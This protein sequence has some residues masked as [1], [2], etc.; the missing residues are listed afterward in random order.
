MRSVEIG[1]SVAGLNLDD[2][3]FDGIWAELAA[4]D[5]LVLLHPPRVTAAAPRLGRYF[6]N[7]LIGNP[8]EN[9]LA[10]A[11]LIFGGVLDRHPRLRIVLPHGGGFCPYQVGRL[12]R[13]FAGKSEC[14]EHLAQP[15]SEYLRRFWYDTI[16][17]RP[18]ALRFLAE[19]VGTDRLVFGTDYPFPMQDPRAV[20]TVEAALP[21]ASLAA[22]FGGTARGLL[23][24]ERGAAI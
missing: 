8:L 22:V 7:N 17:F 23:G 1:T 21:R 6:L 14:R 2:P 11:S 16:T 4:S 9:V 18:D 19:L 20:E 3:R 13:G 5:F 15:P 12:D 24:L 10:A